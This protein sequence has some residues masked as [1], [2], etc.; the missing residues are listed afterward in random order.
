LFVD[1]D[2][3]KII[4]HLAG[5]ATKKSRASFSPTSPGCED[6]RNIYA[7][8]VGE[9]D[10][11]EYKYASITSF[12]ERHNGLIFVN[13]TVFL[14]YF[15]YLAKFC[16]YCADDCAPVLGDLRNVLQQ[17]MQHFFLDSVQKSLLQRFEIAIV[18][19]DEKIRER[20]TTKEHACRFTKS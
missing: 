14:E 16:I 8:I 2:S 4:Y 1:E 7:T 18:G 10:L 13:R 3:M 20:S 11:K 19:V 6:R 17:L 15:V 12:V 5:C 9:C